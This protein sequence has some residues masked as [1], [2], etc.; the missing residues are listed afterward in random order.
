MVRCARG[1]RIRP[2]DRCGVSHADRVA[3]VHAE[4]ADAD[5]VASARRDLSCVQ[6]HD[7]AVV[8]RPDLEAALEQRHGGALVLC[9][10]VEPRAL[11]YRDEI[12]GLDTQLAAR[13]LGD[14]VDDVSSGL[15]HAL[16]EAV[17]AGRRGQLD[18]RVARNGHRRRALSQLYVT[19]ATGKDGHGRCD[20]SSRLHGARRSTRGD[21]HVAVDGHHHD[22]LR[23]WRSRRRACAQDEHEQRGHH[24]RKNRRRSHAARSLAVSSADHTNGPVRHP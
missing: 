20:D 15:A 23:A 12:R 19:V 13:S 24:R 2:F 4:H 16:D 1:A 21:A 5:I 18:T 11:D 17:R 9:R 8:G 10:H 7:V 6:L 3:G 14:L 22:R